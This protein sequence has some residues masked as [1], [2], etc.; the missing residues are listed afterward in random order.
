M[1]VLRLTSVGWT[2]TAT[3][4]AASP[5]WRT[6]TVSATAGTDVESIARCSSVSMETGTETVLA[7]RSLMN[8]LPFYSVASGRLSR[9]GDNR[10]PAALVRKLQMSRR[11]PATRLSGNDIQRTTGRR[12]TGE[13]PVSVTDAPGISLKRDVVKASRSL[14]PIARFS[15]D[16]QQMVGEL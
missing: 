1:I 10:V 8:H 7:D 5:L 16:V 3:S 15:I 6:G 12:T 14:E 2:Q 11:D 13:V 9:G 4:S